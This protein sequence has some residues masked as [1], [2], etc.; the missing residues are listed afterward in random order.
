MGYYV[1]AVLA[2]FFWSFNVIVASFLKDI[3]E[4]WQIAYFR[5]IIAAVCLLPFTLPAIIRQRRILWRHGWFVL[6][7]SAIGIAFS[8][9]CVYYAANTVSAID[10]SL[11]S[12]T[13]PVFLLIFARIFSGTRLHGAQRIGLALTIIGLFLVLLHGRL[14]SFRGMHLAIGDV[15]MFG[16]AS[17]F[18]LY[19]YLMTKKPR[20]LGQTPLL[21]VTVTI[22]ALL[23]LP[24]FLYENTFNPLT[25]H[26]MTPTVIAIMLYMGVFNSV[27]AYL[28][29][30]TALGKLGSLRAGSLYYLMP[31]F[32][33]IAAHYLLGEQIFPAQLAGG[34]VI[35]SGIWL[36][37]TGRRRGLKIER[38]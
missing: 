6:A 33:T 11:I 26:N 17:T 5:W 1:L 23:T 13:G 15:W 30:N 9:T 16:M 18:G 12:V 2:V 3:L 19:S 20:G 28:F 36:T 8:N 22:G 32:S 38:P 34:L 31:V 27:L 7:L 21:A 24:L 35:L 10:M 14:N 29:W 37:N 4:P 25:A